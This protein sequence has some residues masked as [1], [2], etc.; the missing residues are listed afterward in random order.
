MME[1]E[2]ARYYE[3]RM[4][5]ESLWEKKP[6]PVRQI[7]SRRGQG[8]ST[9][10]TLRLTGDELTR[11]AEAAIAL[12]TTPTD[13]IRTAALKATEQAEAIDQAR[14][15]DIMEALTESQARLRELEALLVAAGLPDRKRRTTTA[16]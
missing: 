12:G 15:G 1:D 6:T 3:G 4:N 14:R 9:T 5:D 7:R 10:F 13:F 16:R 8:P 2:R 11:I